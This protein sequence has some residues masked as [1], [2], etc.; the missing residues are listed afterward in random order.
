MWLHRLLWLFGLMDS[1]VSGSRKL[2]DGLLVNKGE[3]L[4][5]EVASWTVVV[6]LDVPPPPVHLEQQLVHTFA[7]LGNLTNKFY[8]L[9]TASWRTRLER[10]RTRIDPE[11]RHSN[12][13]HRRLKRGLFNFVGTLSRHLF[14]TA[15]MAEV[16]KTRDL[17]QKVKQNNQVVTH[18]VK[19]LTTV[20]N[21]SRIY[22]QENRLRI[23]KLTIKMRNIA[24]RQDQ[25]AHTVDTLYLR[26]NVERLVEAVEMLTDA[27][28]VQVDQYH[29]QR[30][31]LEQG[32]MT[33]DLINP[34]LLDEILAEANVVKQMT[35]P[36]KEWYYSYVSVRPV[37][38]EQKFVVFK[39][40]LPLI[41]PQTYLHYL[42]QAFPLPQSNNITAT[43]ELN[44]N[45][46][47]DPHSGGLF[48]PID[49]KGAE[50]IVCRP[51]PLR[52]KEG[53]NCER[54]VITNND[55]TDCVVS[56]KKVAQVDQVWTI[57][58]NQLVLS[59]WGD[60]VIR[61]CKG[62]AE[63][64]IEF[65]QGVYVLNITE[66]CEWTGRTWTF[67]FVPEYVQS[68]HVKL[69]P[70]PNI[71]PVSIP[72]LPTLEKLTFDLPELGQI[73]SFDLK[74]LNEK[75]TM[76]DINFPVYTTDW[77][78]GLMITAVIIICVIIVCISVY[79]WYQK[80]R[81]KVNPPKPTVNREDIELQPIKALKSAQAKAPTPLPSVAE[82]E[83]PF[84]F[85][86]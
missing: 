20:V 85:G 30:T 50:P 38:G 69:K 70:L 24:D 45:V 53:L 33:E 15:T 34:Q 46:G 67:E 39:I 47:Y 22:L 82:R 55:P 83:N 32:F 28:M 12:R 41:K 2:D 27:Y 68:I 3:D 5:L 75:L 59:T 86:N 42:F 79:K 72:S 52:V 1:L 56:L 10:I 48:I 23:N 71:M 60:R 58:N 84:R 9:E 14:G 17:I 78:I 4:L 44:P 61:K 16:Q 35:L 54:A 29:R 63:K 26:H 31:A 65:V 57:A 11:L 13:N 25:L 7:V 37:W 6:T 81:P 49:C 77:F 36:H 73:K 8:P 74:T 62:K 21:Q 76:P 19:E 40:D 80:R 66:G 43:I 64:I 51:S 18:V